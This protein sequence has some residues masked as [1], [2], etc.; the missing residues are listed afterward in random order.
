MS[1]DLEDVVNSGLL[2]VI[3]NTLDLE[4]ECNALRPANGVLV[5]RAMSDDLIDMLTEHGA[6]GAID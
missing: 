6:I 4:Y 5:R 1:I 2:D 3:A